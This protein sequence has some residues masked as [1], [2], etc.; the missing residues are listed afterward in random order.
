M[1]PL[2]SWWRW[3]TFRWRFVA[4]TISS[5]RRAWTLRIPSNH[6]SNAEWMWG[7]KTKLRN[8]SILSTKVRIC[9]KYYMEND[10]KQCWP[11]TENIYKCKRFLCNTADIPNPKNLTM[12]NF[13]VSVEEIYYAVY[14]ISPPFCSSLV[15]I[16]KGEHLKHHFPSILC[17]D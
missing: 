7:C 14:R 5:L 3:P 9:R 6:L 10:L 17:V 15:G 11:C 4:F 8:F 16:F 1:I 13:R 2:S 12:N